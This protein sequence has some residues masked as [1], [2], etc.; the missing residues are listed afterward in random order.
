MKKLVFVLLLLSVFIIKIPKYQELNNIKIIDKIELNYTNNIYKL[1]IRE[2]IL[3]EVSE[4]LLI[5]IK[6][7]FIKIKI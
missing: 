4:E 1:T 7:I 3:K 5:T 6:S 2:I